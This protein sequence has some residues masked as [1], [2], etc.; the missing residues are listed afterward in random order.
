MP[1]F[2]DLR[3]GVKIGGLLLGASLAAT[4]LASFAGLRVLE[5]SQERAVREQVERSLRVGLTL[6]LRHVQQIAA[7]TVRLSESVD[8]VG[9]LTAG[10][11]EL[12]RGVV[13][14]GDADGRVTARKA[15][16]DVELEALATTDSSTLM[17]R[18][19]RYE[20]HATIEPTSRDIV[21]RAVAPILDGS[22]ALRGAVVL[23][24]PL[25]AGFADLLRGAVGAQVGFY[26]G[27]RPAAS[28]FVTPD[29]RR[30]S[31][32]P[33]PAGIE[34]TLE[35]GRNRRGRTSFAG[36]SYEVAVAP[37]QTL[38]GT[39]IGL[40]A[41][42]VDR[43][44]LIEARARTVRTLAQ[45]SAAASLLAIVLAVAFSGALTRPIARL[46][47]STSA[48]AR[49]DMDERVPDMGRDEIGELANSFRVMTAALRERMARDAMSR[50]ELEETVR[51]RTGDLEAA[52]E[53]LEL[54]NVKLSELAI[55]DGLTGLSNHRH[56]Q[57]R[58]ALEVDRSGRSGLPVSLL[59]IDVDHFK[60]YN[61][62]NGHPAGD[63]VLRM[64]AQ[65]LADGRRKTDLVARYGG[66]EFAVLLPDAG[67]EFAAKLGDGLRARVQAKA[68]VTISIG[69]ATCPADAAD[70]AAL[71][72]AADE[73][74]YEAKRAGRNRVVKYSGAP[75]GGPA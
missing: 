65:I 26:A 44:P 71:V 34:R 39:R 13:E 3:L 72:R 57:E 40:I 60:R 61:D 29:G 27:R 68:P 73:A 24:S 33:L 52:K 20:R 6:T 19:L 69:I 62:Q 41:V 74:L 32:F 7:E 64:I 37:L 46:K 75:P 51:R 70:H 50:E 49:G 53:E 22:F 55:T 12:P 30:L 25:D 23:S 1:R 15:V 48:I 63:E 38:E 67:K 17:K 54:A 4:G 11:G 31:G 2:R 58:L 28:T 45:G 8:V 10:A 21:V 9:E 35:D 43:Q 18:G 16:G 47:Q 56:F 59:M 42:A 5:E 36:R 66:E 14:V